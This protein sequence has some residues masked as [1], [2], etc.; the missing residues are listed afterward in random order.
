MIP[1]FLIPPRDLVVTGICVDLVEGENYGNDDFRGGRLKNWTGGSCPEP[2]MGVAVKGAILDVWSP[3]IGI[4]PS[5]VWSPDWNPSESPS[6]KSSPLTQ[7][8][9]PASF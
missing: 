7:R 9:H 1:H 8:D 6:G 2:P 5:V 3:G 4:R